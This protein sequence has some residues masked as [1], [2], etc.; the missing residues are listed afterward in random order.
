MNGHS[1]L[2]NLEQTILTITTW[3]PV[4]PI[5]ISLAGTRVVPIQCVAS[6]TSVVDSC[7][8]ESLVLSLWVVA[9]HSIVEVQKESTV[10]NYRRTSHVYI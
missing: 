2:I 4:C 3:V 5:A 6:V 1:Q 9:Q 7:T 8:H 10:H